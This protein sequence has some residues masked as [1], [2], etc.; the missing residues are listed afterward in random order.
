MTA[1]RAALDAET[2]HSPATNPVADHTPY[3]MDVLNDFVAMGSELAQDTIRQ[4]RLRTE[5]LAAGTGRVPPDPSISFERIG[6]TVRRSIMLADQLAKPAPSAQQ[7]IA[8]R[9]RIIRQVEDAIQCTADGADADNLE[10]EFLERLDSPEF[11][12]DIDSR[13][14][15]EIIAEI[16]RDL[17]LAAMP[18][19]SPWKRRTPDD[20]AA[21][22]ALAAG[23]YR[24]PSGAAG[25]GPVKGGAAR[26]D[27]DRNDPGRDD[28]DWRD[29]AKP[30]PARADRYRPSADWPGG[31]AP[32]PTW[33]DADDPAPSDPDPPGSAVP[34][35]P[36]GSAAE[37]D[38]VPAAANR[39]D[40]VR[41]DPHR[42]HAVRLD[43]HRAEPVRLDPH[44]PGPV[45]SDSPRAEL[46]RPPPDPARAAGVAAAP[47]P[48]GLTGS[49]AIGPKPNPVRPGAAFPHAPPWTLGR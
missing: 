22:C 27:P 8:A 28:K 20:I 45:R 35:P 1:Q 14:I 46:H 49:A 6:R 25:S 17:G 48:S 4:S 15:P 16:C 7:R 31:A 30:I 29:P 21:L 2:P 11:A 18:G 5:A 36:L 47:P 9:K 13:P 10:A 42:A 23:P 19:T 32:K 24:A 26:N 12:D 34:D 44:R 37:P 40:P 39:P 3:Y 43:P 38:L 33:S 41:L